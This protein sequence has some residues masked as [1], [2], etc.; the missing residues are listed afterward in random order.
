[1]FKYLFIALLMI[2]KQSSALSSSEKIAHE[3]REA[4]YQ[5]I[6]SIKAEI[7]N[8]KKVEHTSIK[9]GLRDLPLR[10][11]RPDI[12]DLSPII[13]MIHGGAWVGG[14]LET[15]DNMARYFC[16]ETKA[17]V[18]SVDYLNAPEGK[19]PL[20]L[21]E[22]YDALQ[23]AVANAQSLRADPQRLAVLGDSA[24]GNL[25]AALCLMA[26]DYKEPKINLQVLINPVTDLTGS[27]PQNEE[28]AARMRFIISQ[29]LAHP[30]D[31]KNPYVSPIMATDLSNLPPAL[32]I[33]AEKDELYKEGQI[34]ADL[35]KRAGNKTNV[36]TQWGIG[37]LAG[38]GARASKLAQE[39]LDIAVGALRG[40]FRNNP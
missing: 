11:Y 8:V 2:T 17:I 29:Y 34:Y 26:R 35:L 23:W 1:M 12:D 16:R 40:A 33:L 13:L 15:H 5:K 25:A 3:I 10:I 9:S 32:I 21:N 27:L 4:I 31:A 6:L 28:F 22:C 19:F 20:Q 24:G 18:I 30:E 7:P 14:N 39:S 38:D 36:Y 37:H